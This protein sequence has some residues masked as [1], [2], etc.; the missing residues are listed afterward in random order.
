MSR[1]LDRD[2][3]S[4]VLSVPGLLRRVTYTENREASRRGRS[5]DSPLLAPREPVTQPLTLGIALWL[6]GDGRPDCEGVTAPGAIAEVLPDLTRVRSADRPLSESG[7]GRPIDESRL[8]VAA[9][10]DRTHVVRLA[11]FPGRDARG[12]SGTTPRFESTT[13]VAS[14]T[15]RAGPAATHPERRRSQSF[16]ES[17][18]LP[19][20][21][22]TGRGD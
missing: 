2:Y 13:T 19:T 9:S 17:G 16:R 4:L 15:C 6:T 5:T 14:V 22:L 18:Y 8:V 11:H 3:P 10:I 12:R 21:H 7:L 20:Q 1:A